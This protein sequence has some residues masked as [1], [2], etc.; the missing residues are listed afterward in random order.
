MRPGTGRGPLLRYGQLTGNG[1][2]MESPLSLRA[3]IGTMNRFV[4]VL[5][6]LLLEAKPPGRGR[7]RG[8]KGCSWKTGACTCTGR[9]RRHA[10]F[11]FGQVDRYRWFCD[12]I[13]LMQEN[14]SVT[15]SRDVEASVV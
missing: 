8:R 14:D 2:F 6:V 5:V 15:L 3:Y 1:W 13:D 10:G 7:G 9:G 11:A 4:L 12:K